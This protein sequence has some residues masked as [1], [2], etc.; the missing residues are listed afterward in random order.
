MMGQNYLNAVIKFEV[1]KSEII[2]SSLD[3]L[4]FVIVLFVSYKCVLNNL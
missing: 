1:S 4:T 3:D 2:L